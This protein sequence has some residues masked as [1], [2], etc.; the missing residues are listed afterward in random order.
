LAVVGDDI[1]AQPEGQRDAD[2]CRK[3]DGTQEQSDE[4][5]VL[6]HPEGGRV[7]PGK[8]EQLEVAA[9]HPERFGNVRIAAEVHRQDEGEV[10]EREHKEDDPG[11]C[12]AF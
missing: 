3:P 2:A 11:E 8:V 6:D 1:R 5:Q 9:R 7:Q 10:E 4:P 12:Q